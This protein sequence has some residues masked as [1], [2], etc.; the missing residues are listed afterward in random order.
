MKR[1][2]QPDTPVSLTASSTWS[3]DGAARET[4]QAPLEHSGHAEGSGGT[5]RAA[6][7][8][9]AAVAPWP[10]GRKPAIARRFGRCECGAVRT[11]EPLTRCVVCACGLRAHTRYDAL[12]HRMHQT[13]GRSA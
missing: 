11:R 1:R 9:K 13:E 5:P 10:S 7:G 8:S 3:A 12:S 4:R 6:A 2:V